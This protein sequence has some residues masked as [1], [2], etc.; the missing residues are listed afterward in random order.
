MG[1]LKLFLCSFVLL[2]LLLKVTPA[3]A[4]PLDPPPGSAQRVC[5]NPDIIGKHYKLVYL[6]ES[7]RRGEAAFYLEFPF[8]YITFYPNY[9]YSFVAT[10]KELTNPL[11]LDKKLLWP[12]KYKRVLR[13]YLSP[14]GDLTMYFDKDIWKQFNCI[15][16][17]QTVGAFQKG[18]IILTGYTKKAKSKVYKL[19]R[20]WY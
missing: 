2:A 9:S 15:T 7:P 5:T 1:M 20:I 18:D 3:V 13:F 4:G 12:L 16:V 11:A 10:N 14:K 17:T 19:Y 6:D 8:H